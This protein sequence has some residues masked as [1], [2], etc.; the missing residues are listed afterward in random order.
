ML[1]SRTSAIF[2]F[3]ILYPM[4]K[5]PGP[6]VCLLGQG[7]AQGRRPVPGRH[8]VQPDRHYAGR[9]LT[10]NTDRRCWIYKTQE[11]HTPNS[12]TNMCCKEHC[13]AHR[14]GS[15]SA[16]H[17]RDVETSAHQ[18]EPRIRKDDVPVVP[19]LDPPVHVLGTDHAVH[20]VATVQVS[21]VLPCVGMELPPFN[22]LVKPQ[23]STLHLPLA[24]PFGVLSR[25]ARRGYTAL[26]PA[27]RHRKFS[28][29]RHD[30][31]AHR[32]RTTNA[33]GMP[34]DEC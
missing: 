12:I 27:S 1:P 5:P 31:P 9:S 20:S 7:P 17:P 2:T 32:S 25:V 24:L 19:H 28:G 6:A 22:G 11:S 13:L 21:F 10:S 26:P 23:N 4:F 16:L 15:A 34:V 18:A 3:G 33:I 29:V 8:G 14:T 30:D